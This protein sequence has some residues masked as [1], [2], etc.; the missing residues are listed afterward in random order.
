MS[1]PF[2]ETSLAATTQDGRIAAERAV[3]SAADGRYAHLEHMLQRLQDTDLPE[4]PPSDKQFLLFTCGGILCAAPLINFRE[5]LPVLPQPTALPFSP[6]WALRHL[7]PACGVDRAGHP[8]PMLLDSP[9]FRFC[10]GALPRAQRSADP[11][12]AAKRPTWWR[13]CWSRV[14]CGRGRA[15]AGVR[16]AGGA[17]YCRL[18]RRRDRCVGCAC[19]PFFGL[20]GG[21]CRRFPFPNM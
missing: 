16:G 3:P 12:A 2:D 20:C 13:P 8:A 11:A 15:L 9:I 6:P 7:H 21:L 18:R 14:G 1:T 19:A 17:R 10:A 5:V 4:E